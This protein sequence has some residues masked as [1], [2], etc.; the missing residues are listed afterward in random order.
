[1]KYVV[2]LLLIII[3]YLLALG[4]DCN[5]YSILFSVITLFLSLYLLSANNIVKYGVVLPL[6]FLPI[7]YFSSGM[8]YGYPNLGVIASVMETNN[9]E[10]FE[11]LGDIPVIN[12]ILNLLLFVLFIFYLVK[13]KTDPG[14]L[15]IV[16]GLV[17]LIFSP[18]YA[19]YH[20]IYI[21]GGH[22]IKEHR[23]LLASETQAPNWQILSV[24]PKYRNYVVIIGESMRKD[25]LSAYGYPIDTTPFLRQTKGLLVD[26]YIST[27]PNTAISLPRTL[28]ISDG[29]HIQPADN[30]ITLANKAGFETV[31]ISNQGFLGKYD[32]AISSIAV[33]SDK[34]FFL[35]KGGFNSSDHYDSELLPIFTEH[36]AQKSEKPRLFVLHLMGSHPKFCDRVKQDIYHLKDKQL[37]C[38]L[39]SY[40]E[41]DH[42]IAQVVND[43]KVTQ[44]SFSLVYFSDHGLN[45]HIKGPGSK[46][47]HG[48][49]F[50]SNYEVPFVRISSD[51]KRHHV[52]KK[53]ISAYYFLP[54]F[55]R[56]I[57]VETR[58]LKPFSWKQ[59]GKNV[60]VFNWSKMIPIDQLKADP[61]DIVSQ[62]S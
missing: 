53:T 3:S 38:Y 23:S 41:T 34:K 36:L 47:T 37:S 39:S 62:K 17:V 33:R 4:L 49:Q 44:Q 29:L 11:F 57:G 15:K 12:L 30:F 27:A 61:A 13:I 58:Q 48:N 42:L 52:L 20:H 22:Y 16:L 24:Q 19:F 40:H 18:I 10:M 59:A 6:F 2:P 45:D 50:R 1:M 9:Q 8:Q 56:W 51:D 35:K 43:L 26:G 31:W 14:K 7:F 25:Y 54:F 28:A 21:S 55:S 60:R 5:E 46:L 32:T